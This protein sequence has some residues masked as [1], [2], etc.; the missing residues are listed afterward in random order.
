MIVTDN[1]YKSIGKS[2]ISL[3]VLLDISKAFG[4]VNH[5][6]ILN[7]FVQLNIDSTW[8]E[9]YLHERTHSEKIDRFMFELKFN[10]HL[11]PQG[12]IL[13]PIVFNIFMNDSSK[14]N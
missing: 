14:I 2:E 1:I 5:D 9:S 4:N 12:S 11:V 8:F 13:G 3:L 10:S 7:K 6:L